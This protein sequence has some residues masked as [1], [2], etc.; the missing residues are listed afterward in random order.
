MIEIK[1]EPC[2]SFS[3]SRTAAEAISDAERRG[4]H[5][6]KELVFSR[7]PVI[8]EVAFSDEFLV[9][10]L[11]G[12]GV[13]FAPQATGGVSCSERDFERVGPGLP[14]AIR[15]RFG[16]S[17]SRI[18]DRSELAV[19]LL[20]R[21]L[22]TVFSNPPHIFLSLQGTPTMMLSSVRAGEQSQV[23]LYWDFLVA[24]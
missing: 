19:R 2:G 1:L 18:W 6:L 3:E 22:I 17:P 14:A 11:H 12:T 13:W 4:G 9:F 16:D 23:M 24:D 20:K 21:R 10:R 8:E 15:I 5:L 7:R